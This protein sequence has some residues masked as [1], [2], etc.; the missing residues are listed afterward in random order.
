MKCEKEPFTLPYIRHLEHEVE[1]F[2]SG[3][4]ASSGSAA[5]GEGNIPGR[6]GPPYMKTRPARSERARKCHSMQIS[7]FWALGNLR[8]LA[9]SNNHASCLI[10]S[11]SRA[12]LQ[13]NVVTKTRYQGV[14]CSVPCVTLPILTPLLN[15][16]M[17]VPHNLRGPLLSQTRALALPPLYSWTCQYPH[18]HITSSIHR[19]GRIYVV[20]I[21]RTISPQSTVRTLLTERGIEE[22]AV[23]HLSR[24]GKSCKK[25]KRFGC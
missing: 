9:Q 6:A 1:T 24:L 21:D 7:W 15:T 4:P 16:V 8:R 2:T 13:P 3:T 23:A 25:S 20:L 14:E 17:N 22:D 10:S 12:A 19:D 5:E 18:P 11:T